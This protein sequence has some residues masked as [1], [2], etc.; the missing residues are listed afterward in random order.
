MFTLSGPK[1][2]FFPAALCRGTATIA[3]YYWKLNEAKFA[4]RHKWE[5]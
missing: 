1:T 3:V 4:V 2:H 5:D